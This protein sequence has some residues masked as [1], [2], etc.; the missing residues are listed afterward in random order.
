MQLGVPQSIF[1][2]NESTW[3]SPAKIRF[4]FSTKKTKE[5][6][7]NTS[8]SVVHHAP[9]SKEILKIT[10]VVERSSNTFATY[11]EVVD[12][13]LSFY[14]KGLYFG[15]VDIFLIGQ[16]YKKN[17]SVSKY[18][19]TPNTLYY[20]KYQMQK[21]IIQRLFNTYT[22]PHTIK[23][24]PRDC[25]IGYVKSSVEWVEDFDMTDLD[26]EDL[27]KQSGFLDNP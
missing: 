23:L 7:Y 3:M 22:D 17:W 1:F 19:L 25:I 12:R 5:N 14:C 20:A 9:K 24:H 16:D 27:I 4:S 18:N 26:K 6:F 11:G 15:D 2:A 13:I 21:S 10:L 8:G